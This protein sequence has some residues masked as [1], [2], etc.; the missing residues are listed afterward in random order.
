MRSV[1]AS[2]RGSSMG[3]GPLW[4]CCAALGACTSAEVPT[5]TPVDAQP[6]GDQP[7]MPFRDAGAGDRFAPP[8]ARVE[9]AAHY[10]VVAPDGPRP[11]AP[12]PAPCTL[13]EGSAA[14][15]TTGCMAND[16]PCTPS[17]SD[18]VQTRV[19]GQSALRWRCAGCGFDSWISYAAPAS[20]WDLTS[21]G[22]LQLWFQTAL[23]DSP[24]AWQGAVYGEPPWIILRDRGGR[25]KRVEPATSG[26]P[27]LLDGSVSKWLLVSVPLGAST[28][29]QS[30]TDPGFTP[31]DVTA[32]EIHVDPWGAGFTL[33][34]DGAVFGPGVFSG[35]R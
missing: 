28:E 13:T 21:Y 12:P 24:Y 3:W 4:I 17:L 10:D 33:W 30:V 1:N 8:D 6:V 35:C 34:L 15:W 9:D 20:G 16:M 18:D 25:S 26:S 5:D 11:D 31:G 2:R 22:Y 23:D 19:D 32:L 27:A 14:K 7:T 29:W